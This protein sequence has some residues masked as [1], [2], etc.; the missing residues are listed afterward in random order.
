MK[1]N[2]IAKLLKLYSRTCDS[3]GEATA[4]VDGEDVD[5]KLFYKGAGAA[6]AYAYLVASGEVD[7]ME[8]RRMVTRLP[9]WLEIGDDND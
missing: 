2:A 8:P 7:G 6:F 9:V 4:V 1:K 5:L 3:V